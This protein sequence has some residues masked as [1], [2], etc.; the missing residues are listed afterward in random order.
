MPDK[1][2]DS[3]GLA[4]NTPVNLQK[5]VFSP[6]PSFNKPVTPIAHLF[7]PQLMPGGVTSA[8]D[9]YTPSEQNS[10]SPKEMAE[11]NSTAQ[12]KLNELLNSADSLMFDDTGTINAMVLV[13]MYIIEHVLPEQLAALGKSAEARAQIM[14]VMV[15]TVGKMSTMSLD[16][17]KDAFNNAIHAATLSLV[18][19]ISAG[20]GELGQGIGQAYHAVSMDSSAQTLLRKNVSEIDEKNTISTAK[21]KDKCKELKQESD[22]LDPRKLAR[23]LC[24]ADDDLEDALQYA[25]RCENEA[26]KAKANFKGWCDEILDPKCKTTEPID[27][28]NKYLAALALQATPGIDEFNGFKN[29]AETTRVERMNDAPAISQDNANGQ[30]RAPMIKA[31][32]VGKKLNP[33]ATKDNITYVVSPS[34]I[35][36]DRYRIYRVLQIDEQGTVS[37]T[38]ARLRLSTTKSQALEK[39]YQSPAFLLKHNETIGKV[40]NSGN[41]LINEDVTTLSTLTKEARTQAAQIAIKAKAE[42]DASNTIAKAVADG[43]KTIDVSEHVLNG[44]TDPLGN[45]LR[46]KQLRGEIGLAVANIIRGAGMITQGGFNSAAENQRAQAELKNNLVRI[47]NVLADLV[48]QGIRLADDVGANITQMLEAVVN[49]LNGDYQAL[50]ASTNSHLTR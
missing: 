8:R 37:Y 14:N 10:F 5:P 25:D 4:A 35:F 2:I 33:I 41:I 17:A 43:A 45:L 28:A 3:L 1:T 32:F 18:G 9:F 49:A 15:S 19:A 36:V 29:P 16:L 7:N 21:F 40:L 44:K 47:A 42:Y 46:K 27:K 22:N 48:S 13:L 34:N 30:E 20:V 23:N 24:V 11:L 39:T 26:A 6:V 50:Q 12:A 31:L 38:G